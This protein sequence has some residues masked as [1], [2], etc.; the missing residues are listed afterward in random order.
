MSR[1]SVLLTSLVAV[2]GLVAQPPD[3]TVGP[4]VRVV[5]EAPANPLPYDYEGNGLPGWSPDGR[6]LAYAAPSGG[7]YAPLM[8]L[9]MAAPAEPRALTTQ[10]GFDPTWHPSGESL[11]FVG[12]RPGPDGTVT[13]LYRQSLLGG[14]P[15]DLLPGDEATRG[16]KAVGGIQRWVDASTLAYDG[17]MGTGNTALL[18]VDVSQRRRSAGPEQVAHHFTWDVT[19]AQVAGQETGYRACFW[20]WD[21][22]SRAY[23]HLPAALPGPHQ[24]HEAWS[25]DGTEVLLSA[26]DRGRTYW[27]REGESLGLFRL[28]VAS[29]T[30]TKLADQA[31]LASWGGDLIAYLRLGEELTLVVARPS[32]GEVL[33]TDDLGPVTDPESFRFTAQSYRPVFV[34]RYLAYRTPSGEGRISLAEQRAV[35]TLFAAPEALWSWSPDGRYVAVLSGAPESRLRVLENPLWGF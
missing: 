12:Q 18:F 4:G 21:R 2:T 35:R 32:D 28:G 3:F 29:G 34:G 6:R 1:F 24:Y 26:W 16:I 25:G 15:E 20:L 9:E 27:D 14:D 11:A 17:L 10:P 22:R 23:R 5:A 31:G 30:L 33:W 8:L 7:Q 13:T 19:G